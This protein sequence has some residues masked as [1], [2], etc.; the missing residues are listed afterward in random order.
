MLPWA[1]LS[2]QP[3]W[4]LDQ[5]SHFCTADSRVSLGMASHVLSL[6]IAPSHW[7]IWTPHL[8][9][10]SLGHR[11]HIPNNSAVFAQLTAVSLYFTMGGLFPPQ[12]CPFPWG[13]LIP[14]N[15]WFL[16][17]TW[18]LNPYGILICLTVLQGSLLWH[19]VRPRYSVC[20][21]MPH[22]RTQYCNV[23]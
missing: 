4:H 6:R 7:A 15:T 1:Q 18:V 10:G 11:V 2:P 16:G 9:H 19:T 5:F 8:T 3:K 14:S 22:L 12:N 17:P 21:N 13:I 23:A 20:N